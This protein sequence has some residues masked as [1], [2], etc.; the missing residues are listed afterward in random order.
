MGAEVAKYLPS[1]SLPAMEEPTAIFSSYEN[2]FFQ[3][4]NGVKQSLEEDGS[5]SNG[6]TSQRRLSMLV[7]HLVCTV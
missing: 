5:G 7:A 3:L 1:F 2:E 4:I 6:G